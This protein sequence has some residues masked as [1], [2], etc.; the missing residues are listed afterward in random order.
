M[1]T[2]EYTCK[3]CGHR[4]DHVQSMTSAPLEECPKDLCPKARWGKGKVVRGIGGGGGLIFKGSGFYITDY[5]SEG[6][7][8]AA[9]AD[10]TSP[11][12]ASAPKSDTASKPASTPQG[13]GGAAK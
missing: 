13:G 1:P 8:K 10:S 11:A 5:R 2:Y 12:P 4:F 7:K 6:Y 3:K 9:K